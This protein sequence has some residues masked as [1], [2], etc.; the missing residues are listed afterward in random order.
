MKTDGELKSDV[1]N[2]LAFNP[3]I[4][5]TDIATTANSGSVTLSGFAADFH[6]KH[7][8]EMAAKRVA[9]VIAVANNLAVR[10]KHGDTRSDPELAREAVLALKIELPACWR[11]IQILVHDGRVVLEGTVEWDYQRQRVVNVIRRLRGVLD[12]RNSIIVQPTIIASDIKGEIEAAFKRNAV[13]DAE[14]VKVLVEG[15]QITLK[16]EVGSWAER[17][18]AY[19]TAVSAP[20]VVNVVNELTIQV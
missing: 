4:D 10:P 12:V 16:G 17:D 2:E 14:R 6:E 3:Q 11:M 15:S 13:I 7:L 9:G 20:G 5:A 19:K 8:A 18:Q 1:E